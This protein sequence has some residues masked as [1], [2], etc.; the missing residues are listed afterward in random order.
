MRGARITGW[1]IALP[2]TVVTNAD[3]EARLDTTDS[4]SLIHI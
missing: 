3:Y 1:G 2:D 4:L